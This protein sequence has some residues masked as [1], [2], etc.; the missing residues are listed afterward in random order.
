M[1]YPLLKM[2]ADMNTNEL[3]TQMEMPLETRALRIRRRTKKPSRRAGWWFGQMRRVVDHAIDWTPKPTPRAHQV[4][5]SL[6]RQT[7]QW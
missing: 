7:Q 3:K 4:Y 5:L 6:D 1:S 2:R